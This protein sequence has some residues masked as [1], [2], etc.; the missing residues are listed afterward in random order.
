M[1]LIG[2]VD[3]LL[4]LCYEFGDLAVTSLFHIERCMGTRSRVVS[5]RTHENFEAQSEDPVC[6]DEE[7]LKGDV[8]IC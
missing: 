2:V 1:V 5:V 4:V 6:R 3:P 7:L 8:V